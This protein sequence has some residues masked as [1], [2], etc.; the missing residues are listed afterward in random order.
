MWRPTEKPNIFRHDDCPCCEVE[1]ITYA[2]STCG[3]LVAIPDQE[4]LVWQP[5]TAQA[6]HRVSC[7]DNTPGHEAATD[8]ERDEHAS[9]FCGDKMERL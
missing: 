1:I 6:Y 8:A 3:S 2:C 4:E 7:D 5:T 9:C